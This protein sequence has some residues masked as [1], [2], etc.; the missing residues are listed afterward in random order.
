MRPK[1]RFLEPYICTYMGFSGIIT[2]SRA[3]RR[4]RFHRCCMCFIRSRICLVAW[5]LGNGVSPGRSRSSISA[6]P[7]GGKQPEQ[8]RRW[9]ERDSKAKKRGESQKRSRA[10]NKSD[11]CSPRWC[12]IT[13]QVSIKEPRF[14]LSQK[15]SAPIGRLWAHGEIIN[16]GPRPAQTRGLLGWPV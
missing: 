11:E 10:R 8:Q 4:P 13:G 5:D 15:V 1:D 6:R 14:C 7:E 12:F 16:V 2:S 9:G 3:N